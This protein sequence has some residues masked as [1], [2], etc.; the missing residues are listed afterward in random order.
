M[1][2]YLEKIPKK[3]FFYWG[4]EVLPFLHFL[5]IK[6]FIKYNPDWEVIFYQPKELSLEKSWPGWEHKYKLNCFDY[7]HELLTLPIKSRTF[8]SESLG[9]SNQ[10][11]EI[12]KS[13]FLRWHLLSTEGG[14]WADMDI[15]FTNP[16]NKLKFN[17]EVN[18]NTDTVVAICEDFLPK[19]M[20][21]TIGFMASAENNPYYNH[22]LNKSQQIDKN[23]MDYEIAGNQL[24]NKEFP[25]VKTIQT[26]FPSLT[27]ENLP[28]DTLYTYYPL[29]RVPEF[30]NDYGTERRTG[31][32]IG[33]HWYAGHYCAKKFVNDITSLNYKKYSDTPIGR[34]IQEV[35]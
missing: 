22:I 12:I 31:N 32:S 14:F 27:I 5:T 9:I 25:N 29:E 8:D 23:F 20:F 35:I 21:H 26:R 2:W 10:C 28:F 34:L 13:D 7:L 6:S 3:I 1:K 19:F 15:I 30:F 33:V 11:P 4:A 24:L 16:M 18:K 17:K